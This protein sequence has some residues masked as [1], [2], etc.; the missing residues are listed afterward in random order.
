MQINSLKFTH[1]MDHLSCIGLNQVLLDHPW[2]QELAKEMR[3][4]LCSSI[5]SH[6]PRHLDDNGLRGSA[7]GGDGHDE[8]SED[9]ENEE[10]EDDENDDREN[11]EDEGD[12]DYDGEEI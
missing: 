1:A 3:V 4:L 10:N 8:D 2:I 9:E 6:L 12:D 7:G 5:T 11:D